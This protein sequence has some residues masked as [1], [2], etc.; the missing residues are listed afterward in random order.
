MHTVD[1]PALL[2]VGSSMNIY[3]NDSLTSFSASLLSSLGSSLTIRDN[4]DLTD[5]DFSSL[6]CISDFTIEGN[7]LSDESHYDLLVHLTSGC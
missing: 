4:S 3:G 6:T 2:E 7:D 5:V 1:M